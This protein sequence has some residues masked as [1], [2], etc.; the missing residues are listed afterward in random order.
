MFIELTKQQ[1]TLAQHEALIAGVTHNGLPWEQGAAGYIVCKRG[2]HPSDNRVHCH[3]STSTGSSNKAMLGAELTSAFAAVGQTRPIEAYD[4]FTFHPPTAYRDLLKVSGAVVIFRTEFPVR[5]IDGSIS[6]PPPTLIQLCAAMVAL[7]VVSP[8]YI[9]CARQCYW[10]AGMLYYLLSGVS[11]GDQLLRHTSIEFNDEDGVEDPSAPPSGATTPVDAGGSEPVQS[12][13]T[14]TIAIDVA[15]MGDTSTTT[16]PPTAPGAGGQVKGLLST[17]GLVIPGKGR[18]SKSK[19]RCIVQAGEIS[20]G[21]TFK[22]LTHH[23]LEEIYM[24]ENLHGVWI[25][26]CD[27]LTAVLKIRKTDGIDIDIEGSQVRAMGDVVVS[28]RAKSAAGGSGTGAS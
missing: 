8:R 12:L 10:Y 27:Q 17:I 1:K 11:S 16:S 25:E 9:V 7:H 14:P 24:R 4:T 21:R 22:I 5:A 19:E 3:L 13:A 6:R 18:R 23:T 15:A 20:F 26:Q 28:G 2:V